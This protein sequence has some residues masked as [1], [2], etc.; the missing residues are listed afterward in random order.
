[1]LKKN[2]K[3]KN[4]TPATQKDL[5]MWGGQIMHHFTGLEKD[6]G[7]LEEDVGILKEDVGILKEDVGILKEDVGIL[8]EDVGT[9][10]EDM[11]HVKSV[12]ES[13]LQIVQSID[14]KLTPEHLGLP[15]RVTVLE[16]D[17]FKLQLASKNK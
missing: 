10:K 13:L 15:P 5:E 8:K 1:M 14:A 16:N 4:D 7:N 2:G 17:V 11:K 6:V 9:L 12:Q 3:Q